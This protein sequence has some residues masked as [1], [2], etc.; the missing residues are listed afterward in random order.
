MALSSTM[1]SLCSGYEFYTRNLYNFRNIPNNQPF[2]GKG[3]FLH[4]SMVLFD[5]LT[6]F[7]I[8]GEMVRNLRIARWQTN[9]YNTRV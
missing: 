6:M 2:K 7:N 5:N 4:I 9:E 8:V 1:A 3:T